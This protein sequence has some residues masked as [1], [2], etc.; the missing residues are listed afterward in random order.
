MQFLSYFN[1]IFVHL[2]VQFLGKLYA[3]LGQFLYK[4][5][6]NFKYLLANLRQF[7]K[8]TL[9]DHFIGNLQYAIFFLAI[10]MQL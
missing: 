6:D 3:T 9:W 2:N 10:N 8:Y 4:E 5:K 7:F 1:A